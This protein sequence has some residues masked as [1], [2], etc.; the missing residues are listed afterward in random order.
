MSRVRMHRLPSLHSRRRS[1]HQFHCL[2]FTTM[3]SAQ[4]ARLPRLRPRSCRAT[5]LC[6]FVDLARKQ[7]P[8]WPM[9][10]SGV[11]PINWSRKRLNQSGALETRLCVAARSSAC[12]LCE[13]PLSGLWYSYIISCARYKQG[14]SL[15]KV[16]GTRT[17]RHILCTWPVCCTCTSTCTCTR[18][19]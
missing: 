18:T 10:L 19:R 8:V 9:R 1:P 7:A 2:Y 5:P 11:F 12:I 4:D 6:L 17:Y 14:S 13:K 15:Y 3:I 16:Q